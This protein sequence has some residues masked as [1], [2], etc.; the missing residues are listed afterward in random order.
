MWPLIVRSNSPSSQSHILIVWSSEPE[1]SDENTGWNATHVIGWRCDWS[2][3]RAGDFG[4]Q[5][6]GSLFCLDVGVALESSA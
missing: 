3:C 1:A 6:T 4:N 5:F 2:V